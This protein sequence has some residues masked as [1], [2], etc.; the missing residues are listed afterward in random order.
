MFSL[1]YAKNC[2][3]KV[4]LGFVIAEHMNAGVSKRKRKHRRAPK[5]IILKLIHSNFVVLLKRLLNCCT[6]Y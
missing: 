5:P 1:I 6:L 2:I 4:P 3:R